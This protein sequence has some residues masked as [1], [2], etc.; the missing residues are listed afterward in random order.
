MA[1]NNILTIIIASA[2]GL[3]FNK[4]HIPAGA[5]IGAIFGTAVMQFNTTNSLNIPIK[6]KRYLKV[7][8][9]T[10]IGLGIKIEN[11]REI[12][13]ILMP[14][15]IIFIG[16]TILT[17]VAIFIMHTIFKF[18]IADSLLSSL[19]AGLTEISMNCE[20]FNANPI[21]VT[22]IHF[23]RLIAVLTLITLYI[24]ILA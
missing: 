23:F 21:V 2:F 6:F 3:I 8:I 19:P 20:N 15:I 17:L 18:N 24:Y 14:M 5:M 1:S 9:G 4:L 13:N 12:G 11:M 7:L 16:V 22:T 10:F